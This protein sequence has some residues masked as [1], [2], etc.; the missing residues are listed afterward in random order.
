MGEL[1]TSLGLGVDLG[2]PEGHRPRRRPHGSP[3][4][5]F[6]GM[7]GT[8]ESPDV[9][10]GAQNCLLNPQCDHPHLVHHGKN[11][12]HPFLRCV[13]LL[14]KLHRV[15]LQQQHGTRSHAGTARVLPGGVPS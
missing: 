2:T 9:A 4:P 10:K 13:F 1:S 8:C 3:E 12:I 11:P 6:V 14:G 15:A 7:G 5:V